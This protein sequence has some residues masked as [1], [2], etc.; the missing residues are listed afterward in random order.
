MYNKTDP[1]R[2]LQRVCFFVFSHLAKHMLHVP[3][4]GKDFFGDF[5]LAVLDLCGQSTNHGGGGNG[6]QIVDL[7]GFHFQTVEKDF[8]SFLH[9]AEEHL[10]GYG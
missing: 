10:V 9:A 8:S 6:D 2:F 1:L 5:R 4:I 7:E 3:D